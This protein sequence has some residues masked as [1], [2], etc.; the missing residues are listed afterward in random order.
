MRYVRRR[1]SVKNKSSDLSG[2]MDL[3]DQRLGLHVAVG[4]HNSLFVPVSGKDPRCDGIHAN[5]RRAYVR[6]LS[7]SLKFGT[8]TEVLAEACRTL[9]ARASSSRPYSRKSTRAEPEWLEQMR[10]RSEYSQLRASQLRVYLP[11]PSCTSATRSRTFRRPHRFATSLLN[12][13]FFR[14]LLKHSET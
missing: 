13:Q 7:V 1:I 10:A 12:S 9:T 3:T 5:W 2:T 4:M 14:F 6:S 11:V 8:S